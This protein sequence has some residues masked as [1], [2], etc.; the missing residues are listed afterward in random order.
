M[1]K[2]NGPATTVTG[3]TFAP[4]SSSHPPSHDSAAFVCKAVLKLPFSMASLITPAIT[5]AGGLS[6]NSSAVA[7]QPPEPHNTL[8]LSCWTYVI[9]DPS[10]VHSLV[11]TLVTS[12]LG[13][14]SKADATIAKVVLSNASITASD[15]QLNSLSSRKYLARGEIA[16]VAFVL[17]PVSSVPVLLLVE[18][19]EGSRG[20]GANDGKLLGLIVGFFVVVVGKTESDGTG[21]G[22]IVGCRRLVEIYF[23]TSRQRV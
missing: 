13:S 23:R 16:A 14:S 2:T 17:F 3:L 11:F 10:L 7:S 8:I 5:A 6:S 22:L 9:R 1:F 4:S 19:T 12:W 15:A 18:S 21:D 20:V